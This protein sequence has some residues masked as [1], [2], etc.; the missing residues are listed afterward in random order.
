MPR[1]VPDARCAVKA[2]RLRNGWSQDELA[3]KIR[4]RRQAVYDMESGRYLPNTGVALSL[5]RLFGCSVED[6]FA[7]SVS[8]VP[9]P[10]GRSGPGESGLLVMG[11]DP[12]LELLGAHLLRV[13]PRTVFRHLF[14][15]SRRALGALALGGAHAATTHFHDDEEERANVAAVREFLPGLPCRV[16]GF[17]LME[18]GLMVAAGNPLAIRSASDIA[19]CGARFATREPGAALRA[20]LDAQL[21][22]AGVPA[23]VLGEHGAIVRSH[24]EGARLVAKGKADAALG[25]RSV[26]EAFGLFFVPL[27]AVRCDLVVPAHLEATPPVAALLD[28][29]QSAALRR[30]IAALPGHDSAVTGAEIARTG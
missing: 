9:V 22:K 8:P 29:L 24:G 28:L 21:R 27:A 7:P 16:L 25:L 19:R 11:C 20:L 13:L 26:A 4:V 6:L 12:A 23:S 10:S 18:E 5:A 3:Q 14:A 2:Y 15:S 30:E 1:R 17:S